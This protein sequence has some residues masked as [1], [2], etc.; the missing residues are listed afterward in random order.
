MN[1]SSERVSSK[2]RRTLALGFVVFYKTCSIGAAGIWSDTWIDAVAKIAG[3]VPWAIFIRLT[4]NRL[5][6]DCWKVKKMC[7]NSP[8]W[9]PGFELLL[10]D[11]LTALISFSCVPWYAGTGHCS[12]W[13]CVVNCALGIAGTRSNSQAWVFA[14]FLQTWLPARTISV[15]CTFYL[16]YWNCFG[17]KENKMNGWKNGH[18]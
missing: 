7:L 2:A 14:L 9:N 13:Q 12:Q 15:C 18:V 6:Y 16:W 3:F 8:L 17:V 4:T 5:R 11:F 10:T 1:T